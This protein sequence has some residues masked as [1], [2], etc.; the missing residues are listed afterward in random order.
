MND[1]HEKF[2]DLAEKRV[3]EALK[4]INLIGNLSNKNNYH[5]TE[6]EIRQIINALE[7]S[8][9]ELKVKFNTKS[10]NNKNSFKFKE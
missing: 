4:R 8:I 6:N 3:S 2:K 9:K 5:Y 10:I 7:Q 1:K